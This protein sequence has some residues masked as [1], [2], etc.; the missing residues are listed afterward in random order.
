MA[1]TTLPPPIRSG[2]A[3]LVALVAR[4]LAATS[5]YQ[6]SPALL[7]LLAED[8]ELLAALQ[9]LAFAAAACP[10]ARVPLRA[11]RKRE[12]DGA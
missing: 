7:V 5:G 11:S 4:T 9:R 3:P 1:Q 12:T 8:Y 6:M 2:V 10:T